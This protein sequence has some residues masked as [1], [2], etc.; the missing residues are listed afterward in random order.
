LPNRALFT[1][2]LDHLLARAARR[3]G[4][5]FAVLFLDLDRFKVVNDSLG[6][7]KGD[8]FLVAIARR[9]ATCVRPGDTVARLGGDE[10]TVLLEDLDQPSDAKRVA[11]RIQ[12]MLATPV[13]ID[14]V[15]VY[16]SA[17]IGIALNTDEYDRSEQYLRDA[18]AA[19]YHAKSLGR[20]RYE[21]FDAKMHAD[22]VTRLQLESE[23]R[24]AIDRQEFVVHY[25][26]II[27][28]VDGNIAWFEALVRWQHP[29]RGLIAPDEFIPLAEET[30]LIVPID[31]FVLYEACR[32]ARTWQER[33]PDR[34][35][36]AV[37]VNLSGKQFNEPDL[38][39]FVRSVLQEVG[40]D[41]QFLRLEITESVVM[42]NIDL[43][44]ATLRTLRQ[45]DIHVDMDD[46]GTGYSSLGVLHSFPLNKLKI[47]RSFVD[48]IGDG[49]DRSEVVVA[50][51]AMAHGLHLEV[52][53][54]GVESAEQLAKLRRMGCDYGQ[55]YFFAHPLTHNEIEAL[56]RTNQVW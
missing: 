7:L 46:F 53:A 34:Q 56:I 55:G 36:I 41:G 47:D 13:V 42:G 15:E 18:D 8:Q 19:M 37:S 30:G 23:L 32:Q 35:R 10:F 38:P 22:A 5:R 31:R 25:Q 51:V 52:V 24:H 44:R 27:S 16:T 6:H 9:L 12:K 14:G 17:S 1:E 29:T 43:A 4:Y 49:E 26:P 45:L 48:R 11:N 40:L 39:D 2:R 54:E 28:M 33:F 21:L 50:I 20:S 3:A